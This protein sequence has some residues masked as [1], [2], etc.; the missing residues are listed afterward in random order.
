MS[1]GKAVRC[2][3][4][5]P[6]ILKVIIRYVKTGEVTMIPVKSDELMAEIMKENDFNVATMAVKLGVSRRSIHRL[7][8]GEK[9]SGKVVVALIRP[10]LQLNSEA[11]TTS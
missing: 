6:F 7:L 1:R 8:S 2:V 11:M 5:G 3:R 4:E 10:Y 9:P